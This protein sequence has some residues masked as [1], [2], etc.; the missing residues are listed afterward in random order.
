M[1]VAPR[2]RSSGRLRNLTKT[3]KL[4]ANDQ[5]VDIQTVK[6]DARLE[7]LEKDDYAK[8]QHKKHH[9]DEEDFMAVDD[10]D[11]FST[12][13]R[14]KKT[15]KRKADRLRRNQLQSFT[16]VLENEY[17]GAYP[18]HVP[19]YLTIAAAPSVYPPKHFCSV[20]GY[21][22]NYTCT[23]CGMRFC[24]SRCSTIHQETRCLKWTM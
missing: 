20:C 4:N 1:Q 23:R 19:T 17:Y 24:S 16:A 15:L 7:Q 5:R 6:R 10:D 2:D 21:F 8:D 13:K 9:D 22:S 12:R 18:P 11:A 14:K 3:Y